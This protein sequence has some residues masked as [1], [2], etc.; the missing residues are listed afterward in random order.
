[1]KQE[2]RLHHFLQR[3]VKR[4]DEKVREASNEAHGVCEGGAVIPLPPGYPTWAPEDKVGDTEEELVPRAAGLP[5]IL[6][7]RI[8]FCSAMMPF[9]C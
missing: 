7:C 2:V 1:M 5:T 4:L 3:R 6:L 8:V 9:L